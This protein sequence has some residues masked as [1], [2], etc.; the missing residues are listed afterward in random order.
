MADEQLPTYSP[1]DGRDAQLVDW[2]ILCFQGLGFTELNAVALA[3]RRDID[4]ARVESLLK[5]GASHIQV[6]AIVI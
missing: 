6:M 3:M 4:R 2:R 1:E 5:A